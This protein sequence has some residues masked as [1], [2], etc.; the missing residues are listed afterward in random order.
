MNLAELQQKVPQH[1]VAAL[2]QAYQEESGS[3][4]LA[5]F[6]RQLRDRKLISAAEMKELGVASS[7]EVTMLVDS[8]ATPGE[9]AAPAAPVAKPVEAPPA[10]EAKAEDGKTRYQRLKVLGKG[11][12][13]EVHLAQ[14]VFLARKVAYKNIL[15]AMQQHKQVR[16]RFVGEMQITAQLDHPYIVPVYGLGD[17]GSASYAMKLVSG[18]ELAELLDEAKKKA[19]AGQ[20]L[21][22]ALALEA[23]LDVFL[24]VCDAVAFAHSRGIVH[25]DLKPANIMLGSHGEVYLMDWGIARP[26]GE[27]GKAADAGIELYGGEAEKLDVTKTRV[28]QV[29]GTP[30][31]MSPEQASGLN[32]SL[33]GRSDLY[34]LG[35]ILQEVITLKR[36]VAATTLQ[37]ALTNAK[38]ARRD[39]PQPH[40]ASGDIP[41]ELV[42]IINK[43]TR[44]DPKDRYAGV[45]QLAEDVRRY[46]R[47]EGVLAHPDSALQ[48]T[49]R[50]LSKHRM[51]ALALMM[52]LLL[53]G[54]GTSLGL[55]LYQRAAER[56]QQQHELR[57]AELQAVSATRALEVD[58][59]L[60]RYE[61][62]LHEIG[63]AVQRSFSAPPAAA[64]TAYLDAEFASGDVP[65]LVDSPYYQAKISADAPVFVLGSGERAAHEREL[66]I[67]GSLGPALREAMLDA[68]GHRPQGLSADDERADIVASGVP[69]RRVLFSTPDGV[70]MAFPGTAGLAADVAAK[71]HPAFAR[72]EEPGIHWGTPIASGGAM[73]VPCSTPLFDAEDRF[74]GVIGFDLTLDQLLDKLDAER[75]DYVAAQVLVDVK[76]RIFGRKTKGDLLK[77]DE[78]LPI[79]EVVAA[80]A[81]GKVGHVETR[82]G[83]RDILATYYRLG[84][85][86]WYYVAVV[87]INRMME[88][89]APITGA[90]AVP[91]S[92]PRP[93]PVPRP[94]VPAK[95]PPPPPEPSASASV[96]AEPES[97]APPPAPSNLPWPSA[98]QQPKAQPSAPPPPRDPSANPFDPWKVYDKKGGK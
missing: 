87:E 50:W 86:G 8:T 61:A 40:K 26:M 46:L 71:R 94:P 20:Q 17:E 58:R 68:R 48:A 55:L 37:E 19:E 11:A 53:V 27:G 2:F 66:G 38:Q 41:R 51:A 14:D 9:R 89:L 1:D 79:P 49:G 15:P 65:G 39:P 29:L 67:L 13:G 42:A 90:V 82:L 85:T 77:D 25:R 72:S 80:I 21:E 97:S 60:Q 69:V 23:R 36:A 32:D 56:E 84:T 73:V 35:L 96:S 45:E 59:E 16:T 63:G 33:D 57:L 93:A 98:S 75:L 95:P 74:L 12:M 70:A 30:L 83:S 78:V 43:A 62:A 81:E 10:A 44:L 22:G 34:S 5:G 7:L 24:K 54:A 88:S 76:G 3:N 18:R 92:A 28:G 47:N 4:D 64:P 31:Y 91:S 6:V 52:G